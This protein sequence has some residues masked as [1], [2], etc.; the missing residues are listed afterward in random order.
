MFCDGQISESVAKSIATV[1]KDHILP[2]TTVFIF[3]VPNNDNGLWLGLFDTK[4]NDDV[5]HV[6][7]AIQEGSGFSLDRIEVKN[8]GPRSSIYFGVV[9]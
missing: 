2:Q 3:E 5:G 9:A 1:L 8:S 4:P 7:S 6:L